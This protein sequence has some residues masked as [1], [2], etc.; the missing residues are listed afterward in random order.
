MNSIR[1][2]LP[3]EAEQLTK[4]TLAAK[5]HWKYPETWIQQWLP[6]FAF[7]P[8]YIM[9]HEVWVMS[10]NDKPIAFYS[11]NQIAEELWLEN[12]WVLPEY[13]GDGIGGQLFSHALER[14]RE[15]GESVLKIESDPNAQ[16]FYEKMG[17]QKIDEHKYELDGQLRVLP[18]MAINF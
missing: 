1:R 16:G 12:M 5:R 17:A 3:E 11:F 14:C 2:A 15:R 6:Q 13:I 18:V 9:E 10:A 4:I 8:Q 7:S